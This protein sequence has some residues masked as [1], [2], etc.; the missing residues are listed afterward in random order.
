MTRTI[1]HRLVIHLL[2]SCSALFPSFQ[3]FAQAK[4]TLLGQQM[5]KAPS[6]ISTNGQIAFFWSGTKIKTCNVSTQNCN[7]EITIFPI[8][9]STSS[10]LAAQAIGVKFILPLPDPNSFAVVHQGNLLSIW[11]VDAAKNNATSV[12]LH[13]LGIKGDI[14]YARIL[15]NGNLVSVNA[16]GEVY[17][18]HLDL[19]TSP[20]ILSIQTAEAQSFI[21]LPLDTAQNLSTQLY[22][23]FIRPI[24]SAAISSDGN[25]MVFVFQS[26]SSQQ[27]AYLDK[28][29]N[30]FWTQIL[31]SSVKEIALSDDGKNIALLTEDAHVITYVGPSGTIGVNQKISFSQ[32]CLSFMP[33]TNALLFCEAS[34]LR[35]IKLGEPSSHLLTNTV[36]MDVAHTTSITATPFLIVTMHNNSLETHTPQAA[37]PPET[38]S[39]I[40]PPKTTTGV[41]GESS[42][43]TGESIVVSPDNSY[44]VRVVNNQ[45]TDLRMLGNPKN[46]PIHL[47]V[48]LYISAMSQRGIV[49][50]DS[51]VVSVK[52]PRTAKPLLHFKRFDI[53]IN[54]SSLRISPN[55]KS[56]ISGSDLCN[57]TFYTPARSSQVLLAPILSLP[58]FPDSSNTSCAPINAQFIDNKTILA[59]IPPISNQP[60]PLG[61]AI[62]IS[63]NGKKLKI[64]KELPINLGGE[65]LLGLR[66]SFSQKVVMVIGK[67]NHFIVKT[68]P[69]G[70]S[71]TPLPLAVHQSPI[72]FVAG[73]HILIQSPEGI[74]LMDDQFSSKYIYALPKRTAINSAHLD[75]KREK[76]FFISKDNTAF[77]CN[78][79][80]TC[81]SIGTYHGIT[82]TKKGTYLLDS[83]LSMTPAL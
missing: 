83:R 33:T 62:F 44:A 8:S 29:T 53:D 45:L 20:H 68:G 25:Q 61:R 56:L 57:A 42:L 40:Q 17:L 26:D 28:M 77:A 21:A 41:D 35:I 67:T 4:T 27:I 24:F 39:S 54:S 6:A 43:S 71:I 66:F 3:L 50:Y 46:Q 18:T 47:P 1:H 60:S 10:D 36:P 78:K 55:G 70:P 22:W 31:N 82:S 65:D 69:K 11:K 37:A 30:K 48:P 2:L 72:G 5:Q 14:K 23:T 51:R 16:Q 49:V 58:I 73:G 13:R 64:K 15:T 59:I 38:K 32:P 63:F 76:V 12:H 81:Q 7:P 19:I 52:D 75:L 74:L 9:S 34:G 79:N 80:S